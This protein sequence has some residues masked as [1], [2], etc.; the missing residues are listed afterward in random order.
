MRD[1]VRQE[2]G[3]GNAMPVVCFPDDNAA[4]PDT[5]RLTAV[6]IDPQTEWDDD[7]ATRERIHRWTRERGNSPRLYPGALVWCV[8]KPG[9]ELRDSI[10]D[11]LAWRRVARDVEE[12][13]LGSEFSDA[14]HSEVNDKV[15]EARAERPRRSVGQLPIS[16]V[17]G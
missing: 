9:R 6:V 14:N 2:F 1:L 13:L 17:A 8:K 11:L 3:R 5:R 4:V 16:G 15:H 10:A 7:K 12:G